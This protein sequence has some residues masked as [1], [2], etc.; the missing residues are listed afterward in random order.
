MLDLPSLPHNAGVSR[1]G[2]K[3]SSLLHIRGE[4]SHMEKHS[5]HFKLKQLTK[6]ADLQSKSSRNCRIWNSSGL[7][8]IRKWRLSPWMT[9]N[10]AFSAGYHRWNIRSSHAVGD[11]QPRSYSSQF[12]FSS[13][14]GLFQAVVGLRNKSPTSELGK[15]GRYT[16]YMLCH[17]R[18]L[19]SFPVEFS[20]SVFII[21]LQF[22][23]FLTGHFSDL[24]SAN[25]IA[26]CRYLSLCFHWQS[27]LRDF[28]SHQVTCSPYWSVKSTAPSLTRPFNFLGGSQEIMCGLDSSWLS[29]QH[30]CQRL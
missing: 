28:M 6:T 7:C 30:F 27:L 8:G 5:G 21:H 4:I 17:E 12:L 23:H 26:T 9:G 2:A 13:V 1:I 11:F 3:S 22:R 10:N 25:L 20:F 18:I 16:M 29:W 24:A 15:V 19:A 14:P